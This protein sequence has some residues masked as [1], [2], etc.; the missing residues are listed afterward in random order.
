MT[1]KSGKQFFSEINKT[2]EA[3]DTS[4]TQL[5]RALQNGSE[6]EIAEAQRRLN[7]NVRLLL[8]QFESL[9]IT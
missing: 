4:I 3:T 6:D 1:K 7:E 5:T 8:A 9:H 2:R